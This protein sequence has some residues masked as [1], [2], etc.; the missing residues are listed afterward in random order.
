MSKNTNPWDPAWI[1]TESAKNVA[2]LE[3]SKKRLETKELKTKI[4]KVA[5][6]VA[7]FF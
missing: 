3:K 4:E 5:E 6:K 7:L 2:D 1:A